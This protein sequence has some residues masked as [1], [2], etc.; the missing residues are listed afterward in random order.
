MTWLILRGRFRDTEDGANRSRHTLAR[1][2]VPSSPF[3][4]FP[5]DDRGRVARVVTVVGSLAAVVA[6]S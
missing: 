6:G 3:R 5:D 4:V 2:K 1:C